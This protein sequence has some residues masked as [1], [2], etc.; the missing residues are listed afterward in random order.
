[1]LSEMGRHPQIN[2]SGG[3]DHWTYTSAMLLG[4]GVRGG[5]VIGELDEDF[6][7]RPVDLVTGEARD[8]GTGLVPGHLGAT[9][10]ALGGVDPGDVLTG[11][12]G[13]IEAALA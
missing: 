5:Q 12:E 3:R 13:V 2:D 6:Q 10:L 4:A 8:D 11:G 7:G 9:L 1:V